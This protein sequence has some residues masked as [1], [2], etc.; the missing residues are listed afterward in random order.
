MARSFT[1]Q[2]LAAPG[3]LGERVKLSCRVFD[4]EGIPIDDAMIEIWQANA[5]GKYSHPDDLQE[6]PIDPNFR[7]FGR[8]ATDENGACTFETIKPGRVPG[9][10]PH[11][12]VSVFARGTLDR[13]VTRIYF[14]ADPAN[15]EDPILARVPEDRRATLMAQP[16]SQNPGAWHFDIHLS[17][18]HETVFFDV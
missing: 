17:G 16:D 4:G 3:A 1:W 9:K 14:A 5:A 8:S 15:H 11:I 2:C 13:F 6:K 7:G 18:D 10:A 12:N